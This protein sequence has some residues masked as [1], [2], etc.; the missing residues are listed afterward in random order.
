[1]KPFIISLLFILASPGAYSAAIPANIYD[2]SNVDEVTGN[3]VKV[4]AVVKGAKASHPYRV[5]LLPIQRQTIGSILRSGGSAILRRSPYWIAATAAMGLLV[6][7]DG[8]ITTTVTSGFYIPGYWWSINGNNPA[9][10]SNAADKTCSL[11][12]T[13]QGWASSSVSVSGSLYYCNYTWP[14]GNTGSWVMDKFPCSG[15]HA[16]QSYCQAYEDQEKTLSDAEFLDVALPYIAANPSRDALKNP[17]A[18]NDWSHLI[19]TDDLTYIPDAVTQQDEDYI[20]YMLDGI[21]QST[22]SNA[23]GYIDPADYDRIADMASE[24]QGLDT[25]EGATDALNAEAEAA[26]TAATLAEALEANR[27]AEAEAAAAAAAIE[28]NAIDD[29][30]FQPSLN[31]L[32]APFDDKLDNIVD[33]PDTSVYTIPSISPLSFGGGQCYQIPYN[34]GNFGSGTFDKH[35]GPYYSFGLPL[36]TWFLYLSTLIYIWFLIE[37]RVGRRVV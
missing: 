34:F 4:K 13:F 14:A 8:T 30:L 20:N 15:G 26:I 1:M 32:L 37:S 7:D 23:P 5:R 10:R 11:E 33:I 16:N 3:T 31:G 27:L 6:T 22:D 29:A 36:I 9:T 28:A 21:A 17:D 24:I 19:P 25:P 35:C 2:L 18:P 12:K